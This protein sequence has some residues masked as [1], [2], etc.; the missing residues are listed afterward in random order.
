MTFNIQFIFL[1]VCI[2]SE[3]EQTNPSNISTCM[4]NMYFKWSTCLHIK[5]TNQWIAY[6][7]ESTFTLIKLRF[8]DQTLKF[9]QAYFYISPWSAN[10]SYSLPSL[11]HLCCWFTPFSW[12]HISFSI[13]ESNVLSIMKRITAQ[14]H[15]CCCFFSYQI[16]IFF[17]SII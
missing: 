1:V 6:D 3:R 7:K 14:A 17:F 10:H 13:N 15:T 5:Y 9:F 2:I 11:L 4:Y 8:T 16:L 12:I